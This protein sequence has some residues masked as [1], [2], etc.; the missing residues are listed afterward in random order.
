[1]NLSMVQARF[2]QED[3]VAVST[4]SAGIAPKKLP[5]KGKAIRWYYGQYV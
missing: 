3:N 5:A 1:M 2:N 4:V